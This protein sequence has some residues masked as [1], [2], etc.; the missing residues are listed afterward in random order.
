MIKPA[1]INFQ[2]VSGLGSRLLDSFTLRRWIIPLILIVLYFIVYGILFPRSFLSAYN[3]SSMALEFSIPLS[4]VTIAMALMLI[5]GEI[6]LSVGY[7]I[8]FGNMMAGYLAIHRL[9]LPVCIIVPVVSTA[10]VGFI[11]GLL[12]ARVGINSFIA[13][14]GSGLV[15]YGLGLNIYEQ[16][17]LYEGGTG[18]Q[19]LEEWFIKISQTKLVTFKDTGAIQI[20]VLYSAILILIAVAVM[21]KFR[22]FRKYYYIGV[23]KETAALSG[24]N[25]KSMKAISF[26]ISSA[27]AGTA[28]V[29]MSARMGA[30][31]PTLGIGFELKAI[32]AC[33][34]GGVSFK[35]G[36]GTIGGAV[37][38][39]LFMICLSNG[40]RIGYAPSNIYRL[41]EGS[42]LLL[43]VI[44]D[45]IMSRRKVVG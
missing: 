18:I 34:I 42:V 35:G 19:H 27:L 36:T 15:F 22:Y 30:S 43:A 23:N 9:P 14:L 45:A 20:P 16:C 21:T 12:V 37:L 17:R 13:T 31:V 29:F 25:V 40:L 32:T 28:G 7:A 39:G 3:I 10:A 2:F 5:S 11:V 1:K 8:L 33:V 26:M 44:A 4:F 38:G 41:I 6:D 24:I